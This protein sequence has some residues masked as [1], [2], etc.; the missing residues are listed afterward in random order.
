MLILLC[1]QSTCVCVVPHLSYLCTLLTNNL[2]TLGMVYRAQSCGADYD[3]LRKDYS[4]GRPV[5]WGAFSSTSQN[6]GVS[7]RFINKAKGVLFK[8]TVV[9][10][11]LVSEYSLFP[12][13]GEVLLSP[14]TRF[15][16]S[17]ELYTD[18]E[19]YACIDL[20]EAHG[21]VFSS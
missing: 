19:G 21:R 5:Q 7:K 1:V 14:N 8:L 16:V 3:R 6:E 4:L 17:R 11:A 10:G 13:E 2:S 9:S 12:M 15:T 20:L 18:E